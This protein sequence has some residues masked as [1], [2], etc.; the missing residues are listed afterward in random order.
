[1]EGS[2][3]AAAAIADG[4][5][6]GDR[7]PREEADSKQNVGRGSRQEVD[8]LRLKKNQREPPQGSKATVKGLTPNI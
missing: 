4:I 6:S 1:M 5:L 7:D 8:S 3:D 2:G